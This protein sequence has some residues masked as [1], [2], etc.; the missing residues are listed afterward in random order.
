MSRPYATDLVFVSVGIYY[1]FD[2]F[3]DFDGYLPVLRSRAHIVVPE[4]VRVAPGVNRVSGNA[5]YLE[6]ASLLTNLELKVSEWHF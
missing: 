5:G 3:D 2:I 1:T 6:H 4:H